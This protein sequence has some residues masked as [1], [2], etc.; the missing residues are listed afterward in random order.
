MFSNN[1]HENDMS[2]QQLHNQSCVCLQSILSAYISIAPEQG[3][4]GVSGAGWVTEGLML[5]LGEPC[6]P[7]KSSSD[8]TRTVEA[9][10]CPLDFPLRRSWK[11]PVSRAGSGQEKEM[12]RGR[13]KETEWVNRNR[14]NAKGCWAYSR[15]WLACI[16]RGSPCVILR[17]LHWL[18]VIELTQVSWA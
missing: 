18:Y 17:I 4:A 10:N 2:S 11:K 3:R 13:Q 5:A 1:L 7:V 6:L 9:R 15:E 16:N 8:T 14:K 12:D